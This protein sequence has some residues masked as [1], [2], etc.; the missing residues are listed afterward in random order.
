MSIKLTNKKH[1]AFRG[2]YVCEYI[3]DSVEDV[4]TLPNCA[5]GSEA[6]VLAANEKYV[7]FTN[8]VWGKL[9]GGTV[10]AKMITFT[11]VDDNYVNYN[12]SAAE[13]TTLGEWAT[14]SGNGYVQDNTVMVSLGENPSFPVYDMLNGG[15]YVHPDTVIPDGAEYRV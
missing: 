5:V 6:L 4:A 7:V 10:P 2:D 1:C 15:E 11:I 12:F 9:G 14:T 3:C 8:G 13:G